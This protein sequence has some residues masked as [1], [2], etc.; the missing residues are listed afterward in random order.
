[1]TRMLHH[2]DSIARK[3]E[4]L[5]IVR[6]KRD[7]AQANFAAAEEGLDRIAHLVAWLRSGVTSTS[8]LDRAQAHIKNLEAAAEAMAERLTKANERAD[9][10]EMALAATTTRN[11][12][13]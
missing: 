4:M 13:A 1:M 7:M 2:L 11:I 6:V 3:I 12:A 5:P 9:R 8:D 10:A